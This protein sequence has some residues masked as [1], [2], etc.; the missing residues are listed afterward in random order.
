MR[1][2]DRE[3]KAL[4][5]HFNRVADLEG[6]LTEARAEI[7][8]LQERDELLSRLATEALIVMI[9]DLEYTNELRPLYGHTPMRHSG[10]WHSIAKAL[11]DKFV[12]E[13]ERWTRAQAENPP[14][15]TSPWLARA[16]EEEEDA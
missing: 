14:I 13:T 8:R 2:D 1:N 10:L 16:Q 15:K 12:P 7:E 6:E 5:Y 4:A 3:G 9:L 11:G